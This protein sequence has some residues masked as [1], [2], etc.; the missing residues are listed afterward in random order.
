MPEYPDIVVYIEHLEQ[1]I[2]QNVLHDIRLHS[3]FFLRTAEPPLSSLH[4]LTVQKIRRLGKRIVFVFPDELFLVLHLMIVGRLHWKA[5]G[6]ALNRKTGLAALDF[7]DGTLSIT[8]SG[9][10]KRASLHLV[11]GEAYLGTFDRGG[12]NVLEASLVEF[13]RRL[14]SENHTLKRTLTD[15]RLFDGIGNA[16]SDEILHHARLS[17]VQLTQRLS[18]EQIERLYEA[19]RSQLQHWTEG[20]RAEAGDTFPEK[21]TAFRPEMAVHGKF[22]TPCPVCETLVQRIRY[23]DNETNYC[24]RCQTEGKLLSDRSLA[25]LLRNDWPKTIDALEN[26]QH[27]GR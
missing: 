20:L 11:Q 4:G 26:R 19:C 5:P 9:S 13:A 17:P 27:A 1:R 25:R 6:A 2:N 14:R 21:V 23:A 22:N 8:E 7:A 15:P 12:L 16:Y 24:P 18:E 3:P 10:K